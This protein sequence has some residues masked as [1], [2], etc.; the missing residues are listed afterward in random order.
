MEI[1]EKSAGVWPPPVSRGDKRNLNEKVILSIVLKE[2]T[3]L[4]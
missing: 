3:G 1:F 2:V 4:R